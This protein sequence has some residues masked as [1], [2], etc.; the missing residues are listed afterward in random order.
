MLQRL[1]SASFPLL[2]ALLL[3]ACSSRAARGDDASGLAPALAS[4]SAEELMAH[5]RVLA[6]DAF[7]GR[8]PGTAGE[9][10]TV[11]YLTRAFRDLGLEPGNPD[12]SYVQRVP[13]L[14]HTTTSSASFATP[15][16][17]IPLAPLEDYVATTRRERVSLADLP[18]VFVGYGTVAPEEGWDDYKGVDVRGKAIVML[19]NDP[20]VPLADD[21]TRRDP[22]VFRGDAMTYYGRWTYKYEVAR[23]KGAAAAILVHETGPAGYPWEVVSGSWGREG[24]DVAGAEV[25]DRHV[26][27]EAWI[28]RAIAE[29]LFAACGLDF[30]AEKRAA[31]GRDF[32]PV[33][34][35]GARARFDCTAELRTIES[36]NVVAARRGVD[37]ARRDEWIVF[38]AH[39]DHLGVD[40][41]GEGDR[42]YNGALDNASGTA[43]LLEIAQAFTRV[44][45]DRSLLFLAVTGE[46]EGLLGSEHYAAHPLH[47]LEKTLANIN[48]DGLN[49]YGRTRDVVSIGLGFSSLDAVLERAAAAQERRVVPDP[50]P[51]K[52]FYFRSDHFS[53]VRRGV[54]ALYAE[55]GIDYRGRPA[56][57]GKARRDRYTAE[58]YHQPSDEVKDDWDLAGALEDV[59][60][61]LRVA[62]ALAQADVWPTWNEGS[63]FRAVR[64]A[65]LAGRN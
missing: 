37:P 7:E 41:V 27:V 21:P 63:E 20:P 36:Q 65:M 45:P 15:A 25:A 17:A 12:G 49:P 57:W 58:D 46:E 35:R 51:E 39:W 23:E 31:L 62:W 28:Q 59:A 16:G 10:K 1:P 2:A 48:M 33:E 56:G 6:S 8:A 53:F 24:F 50:E 55:S 47:P 26:A 14:G 9:R 3:A 61:Y 64:A 29:R 13:L 44:A 43:A 32:R 30:E 42:I 18:L 4:L 34:L 40:P 60:L 52:G 22:G 11:E 5:V 19:V 54:P 38:S